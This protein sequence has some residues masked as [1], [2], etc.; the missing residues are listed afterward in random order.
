MT[1][2]FSCDK[3][4]VWHSLP[5]PTKFLLPLPAESVQQL[6]L[7]YGVPREDALEFQVCRRSGLVVIWQ[8]CYG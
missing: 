3:L 6:S 1:S 7:S 4:Y 5:Y 2:R 8:Q